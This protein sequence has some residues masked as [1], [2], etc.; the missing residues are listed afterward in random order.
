MSTY[1]LNN[2]TA[3]YLEGGKLLTAADE[4]EKIAQH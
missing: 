1:K 3:Q 2:K 4:W